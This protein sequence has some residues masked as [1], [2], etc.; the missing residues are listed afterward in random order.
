[1]LTI[2]R[3]H[4]RRCPHAAKGRDWRRCSCPI[5]VEGTLPQGERVRKTL[6]TGSWEL[7]SEMVRGMEAGGPAAAV[8]VED[9]IERFLA[10]ATARSLADSSMKKYRVLLQG[11]RNSDTSSA[12]LEEFARDAG[13]QLLKQLDV[14]ALRKFR[15]EWKDGPRS[16]RKKLERLRTFFKFA[17]EAGWIASNPALAIKPP[18]DRG[19]PTMPLDDD[20]LEKIHGRL[21]EF[22][23]QRRTAARG[24][25]SASDHLDRLQALLLLLEHTGLRIIDAVTLNTRNVI[26]GR[27][28]LRA[29]KNRGEINLPLP[30]EVLTELQSFHRYN[31][32]CYF[33]TGEGKPETAA[34]NYRRTLRDLGRHCEAPDLHPHR[35]RDTFAVRLLQNGVTLDRVARALGD[36]SVRVVEKHYAPWIKSRQDEL[37]KDIRATWAAGSEPRKRLVRV[38]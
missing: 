7:A 14:D 33:W 27:V 1:M 19:D 36:S 5:S 38:K 4:R 30:A 28:I 23:A 26:D 10:D 16:A 25:A 2:F 35:L 17:L 37:D 31:G 18:V 22:I 29:R 3:R 32:G 21:G 13:Y 20:E 8:T 6:N 9:A 15:Q 24:Q 34:G 12:T 11:R